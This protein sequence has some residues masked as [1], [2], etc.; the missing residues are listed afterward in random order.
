MTDKGRE[1]LKRFLI[2]VPVGEPLIT[3]PIDRPGG[4]KE[5]KRRLPTS[6]G[7]LAR[8]LFDRDR[9]AG[10]GPDGDGTD[11]A[12]VTDRANGVDSDGDCF[13]PSV[14]RQSPR[15]YCKGSEAGSDG[16]WVMPVFGSSKAKKPTTVKAPQATNCA[17]KA[18]KPRNEGQEV[19]QVSSM[20]WRRRKTT[21]IATQL[22]PAQA[23]V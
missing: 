20:V 5:S 15:A 23:A 17:A 12:I 8:G 16:A 19:K 7:Q 9:F 4:G 10:S 18:P 22:L 11:L 2:D 1:A 14:H 6:F 13:D 21:P 3:A